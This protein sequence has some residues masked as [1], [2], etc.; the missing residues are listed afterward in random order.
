MNANMTFRQSERLHLFSLGLDKMQ[1]A[2]DK[3][4]V[5]SQKE[6]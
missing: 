1:K 6:C 5:H 2:E 4:V 3:V